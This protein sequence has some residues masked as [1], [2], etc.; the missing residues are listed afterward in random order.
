[1]IYFVLQLRVGFYLICKFS[2]VPHHNIQTFKVIHGL[3]LNIL[4]D[5]RAH[6]QRASPLLQSNCFII[7]FY[8]YLFQMSEYG[9]STPVTFLRFLPIISPLLLSPFLLQKTFNILINFNIFH[10]FSYNLFAT[11]LISF[12]SI[13]VFDSAPETK[14]NFLAL[15]ICQ[16]QQ[17]AI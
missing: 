17:N 14:R 16:S 2:L 7:Y 6:L 8:F 11:L 4:E 5:L 12:M 13:P 15:F 1:M 10:R 9:I 3:S